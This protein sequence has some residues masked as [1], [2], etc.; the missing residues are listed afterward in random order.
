[1]TRRIPILCCCTLLSACA[2]QEPSD[3][4]TGGASETSD[5]ACELSS[6]ATV[7]GTTIW[8]VD[9]EEA[10]L[11]SAGMSVDADGAPNAYLRV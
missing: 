4:E 10:L 7:D 9:G 2:T 5:N 1:M 6:V 8:K 11:F 3:G